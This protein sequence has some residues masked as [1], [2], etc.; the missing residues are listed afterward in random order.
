MC[1]TRWLM[2]LRNLL[3]LPIAATIVVDSGYAKLET[4]RECCDMLCAEADSLPLHVS[5]MPYIS[6]ADV[7]FSVNIQISIDRPVEKP[8]G[9]VNLLPVLLGNAVGNYKRKFDTKRTIHGGAEAVESMAART[10][11][12]CRP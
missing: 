9:E 10:G 7:V 6:H 5:N 3:H 1:A 12:Y 8:T 11:R 4:F 2:Q